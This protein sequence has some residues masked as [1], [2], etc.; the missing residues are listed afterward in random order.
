LQTRAS[1]VGIGFSVLKYSFGLLKLLHQR[2]VANPRQP[3][4]VEDIIISKHSM[5]NWDFYFK[6]YFFFNTE[7]SQV[8]SFA[9]VLPKN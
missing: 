6:I 8:Q 7:I 1:R 4:F 2:W 9:L 3:K 5:P